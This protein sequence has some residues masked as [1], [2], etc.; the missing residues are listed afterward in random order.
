[1]SVFRLAVVMVLAIV[2]GL[3][4]AAEAGAAT[5]PNVVV[6]VTDDMRTSDWQALPKTQALLA[7]G[8]SFP[9]FFLTTPTCCPSRTSI[10]T[11][12]YAHNHGVVHNNPPI[13]GF[14][15]FQELGLENSTV[16]TWLPP[17]DPRG[18]PEPAPQRPP[19]HPHTP[20]FFRAARDLL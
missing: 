2:V 20:F 18:L 17:A 9:N 13:G 12:Q 5:P 10:L 6:V 14:P 4:P 11:G 8:T 3:L 15:K 1:M 7:G 16:A 19:I